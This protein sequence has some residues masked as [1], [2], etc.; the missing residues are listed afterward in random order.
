MMMDVGQGYEDRSSVIPEYIYILYY[1][2]KI[3][4]THELCNIPMHCVDLN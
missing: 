1:R 4:K 3:C 2:E